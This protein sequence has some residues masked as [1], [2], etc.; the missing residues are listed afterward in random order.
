MGSS[1]DGPLSLILEFLVPPFAVGLALGIGLVFP[2]LLFVTR[3]MQRIAGDPSRRFGVA[4]L[5][6]AALWLSIVWLGAPLRVSAQVLIHLV[7]GALV[8]CAAFIF[9]LGLW[10]LLTRGCSVAI[11]LG[12]RMLGDHFSATELGDAYANSRGLR[13]LTDKRLNSL[14]RA[15]LVRLEENSVVVTVPSGHVAALCCRTLNRIIGLRAFG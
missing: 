9:W 4:C 5:M 13:W 7:N 10:G 8:L 14:V 12:G 6:A 2:G 1:R 15:G 3:F 11:L